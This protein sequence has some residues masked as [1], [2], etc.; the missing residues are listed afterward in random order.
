MLYKIFFSNTCLYN[1]VSMLGRLPVVKPTYLA[2]ICGVFTGLYTFKP[3][4]VQHGQKQYNSQD[5][6]CG[7]ET[8]NEPHNNVKQ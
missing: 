7:N 6:S 3:L 5:N 8:A 4:L 2:L 1:R